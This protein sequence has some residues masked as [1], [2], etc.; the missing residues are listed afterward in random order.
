MLKLTN[1]CLCLSVSDLKQEQRTLR[2]VLV[3]PDLMHREC[4]YL[5]E[6]KQ[7][8]DLSSCRAMS[9]YIAKATTCFGG[10]YFLL[11]HKLLLV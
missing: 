10:L 6:T 9:F 7:I 1:S 3:P 5:K 8:L 2:K 11:Q 4:A